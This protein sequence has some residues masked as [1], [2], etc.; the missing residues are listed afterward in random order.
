MSY[1]FGKEFARGN[2]VSFM[3][4]ELRKIIYT[5]GR[6]RNNLCK[7]PALEKKKEFFYSLK[8]VSL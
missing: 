7:K 6:L 2:Q 8:K 1:A 4:N 3:N 5:R